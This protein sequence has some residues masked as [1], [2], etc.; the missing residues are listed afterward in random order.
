MSKNY[1][2]LMAAINTA[3]NE[4]RTVFNDDA[5]T[6][7]E[8]GLAF[9][10]LTKALDAYNS[11]KREDAYAVVLTDENPVKRIIDDFQFDGLKKAKINWGDSKGDDAHKKI[12]MITIDD[13]KPEIYSLTT[14]DDFA[15]EANKQPFASA[16]WRD[17]VASLTKLYNSIEMRASGTSGAKFKSKNTPRKD[18][19]TSYKVGEEVI[20]SNTAD[21][22]KYDVSMGDLKRATQH[23]IDAILF[24]DNGKGKNSYMVK[25]EDVMYIFTRVTKY[26]PK[27]HRSATVKQYMFALLLDVL[28]KRVCGYN[29]LDASVK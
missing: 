9:A 5:K 27:T 3:K 13:A 11:A 17:E 1:S 20:T 4:Y 23:V 26:N 28:G 18:M 7:V 8:K 21:A 6:D 16:N 19:I 10:K 22:F 29:Y 15:V 25:T 24:T 12:S 14:L 2:E